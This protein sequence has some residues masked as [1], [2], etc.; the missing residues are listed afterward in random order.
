MLGL[1]SND[2]FVIGA[3]RLNGSYGYGFASSVGHPRLDS[4]ELLVNDYMYTYL[5]HWCYVI[6][7]LGQSQPC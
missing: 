3:L 2:C 5:G 1:G 6:G 4:A 7:P